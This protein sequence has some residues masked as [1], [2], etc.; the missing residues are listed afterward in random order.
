MPRHPRIALT[1]RLRIHTIND[2]IGT[3]VVM[4][5]GDRRKVL[6]ALRAARRSSRKGSHSTQLDNLFVYGTCLSL[7]AGEPPDRE[8]PCRHGIDF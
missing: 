2:K 4:M 1:S 3:R 7:P 6:L 8:K 5:P